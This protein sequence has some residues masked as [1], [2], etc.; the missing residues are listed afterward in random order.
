MIKVNTLLLLNVLSVSLLGFSFY[1]I[2]YNSGKEFLFINFMK[3]V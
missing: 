1:R 3:I 2:N